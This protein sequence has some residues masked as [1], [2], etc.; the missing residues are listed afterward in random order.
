MEKPHKKEKTWHRF[1]LNILNSF[2]KKFKCFGYKKVKINVFRQLMSH[3][4]LETKKNSSQS[5]IDAA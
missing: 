5:M 1:V 3:I 2:G 4:D